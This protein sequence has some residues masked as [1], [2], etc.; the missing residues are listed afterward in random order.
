MTN[1]SIPAGK[2]TPLIQFQKG[3]LSFKGKAFPENARKFFD[4]VAAQFK[5]YPFPTDFYTELDLDY[6]SSAAVICILDLL[7]RLKNDAPQT[8]F[9]VKFYYDTGD[10][11]M[12][13]VGENYSKILG[14]D[15]TLMPR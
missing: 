6:M 9:H 1:F 2:N 11:D 8:R 13:A 5:A 4:E 14:Q 15:F 3:T 10:D 12:L 7:K